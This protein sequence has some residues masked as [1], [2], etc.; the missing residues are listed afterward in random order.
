MQLLIKGVHY[1]SHRGSLN[2]QLVLKTF[3]SEL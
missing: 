1:H 2:K 3:G